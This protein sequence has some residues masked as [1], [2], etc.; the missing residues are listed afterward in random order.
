MTLVGFELKVQRP[1]TEGQFVQCK[2]Q[3]LLECGNLYVSMGQIVMSVGHN[4]LLKPPM[5]DRSKDRG[6]TMAPRFFSK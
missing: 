5:L 1:N 2:V 3:S 4:F 6:K